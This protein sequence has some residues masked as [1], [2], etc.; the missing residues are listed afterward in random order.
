M[1][2]NIVYLDNAATTFPKPERVYE[3]M[4][5][6]G[7]A[8]G[9]NA[10]RSSY[11]LAKMANKLIDETKSELGSLV[12][13]NENDIVFSPSA[14]IAF[15]QILQGLDF[16]TINNVYV[17]PFEHNAVMRTLNFLQK[18]YKF[19]IIIIPFDNKT[20]ELDKSKLKIKFANNNPDI[21]IMSHVSNVTGYILPI[22]EII[23]VASKYQP[24]VILDA[25]Q[26]LGLISIDLSKLDVDF[27]VFA[28]HKT[29]YGPFGI[30]GFINNYKKGNL[31]EYI[32][33]GTGSDSLNLNMPEEGPLRYEAGSQNINA[34]A[35]LNAS[36]KWIK[37]T[38]V[39]NIFRKK[40]I[41]TE[42]I[43]SKLQK[44]YDINLYIPNNLDR[45][46]GIVSFCLG[47]YNSNEL[48][49]ILDEEFNISVRSG[50][51]CSPFMQEFLQTQHNSGTVRIS[52]GYFNSEEDIDKLIE[53][54]EELE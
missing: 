23:Q 30:A 6:V 49:Q 17:T 10:G 31:N 40:K 45:H 15:N 9:V 28:G 43:I 21:I 25:A 48:G 16:K 37:E 3:Q 26:S 8:Y 50:Y 12:N 33:G 1:L 51:H 19:D 29:L 27:L 20:F 52:L 18:K 24:I 14:T 41:L 35:G 2:D 11:K 46:I 38:G 22:E 4:D 47:D 53:S 36:L 32:L 44:L 7:R 34:V 13:T 5:K 39:E 42:K 54:L